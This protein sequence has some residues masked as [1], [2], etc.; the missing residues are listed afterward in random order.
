MSTWATNEFCAQPGRGDDVA[1][2]LIEI[3]GESI[4]F[5]GCEI[6]RIVRDQVKGVIGRSKLDRSPK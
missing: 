3:L 6:V 5:D 1:D 4:E 2:L